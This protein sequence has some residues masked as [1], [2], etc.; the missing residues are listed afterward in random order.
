METRNI[1]HRGGNER[2]RTSEVTIQQ[3]KSIFRM[4]LLSIFV[5]LQQITASSYNVTSH[6]VQVSLF[7]SP[8]ASDLEALNESNQQNLLEYAE[9]C[10]I[11]RKVTQK[12]YQT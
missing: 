5:L 4:I 10:S 6:C 12:A 1:C 8:Q 7:V 9:L 2:L 11:Q 3:A